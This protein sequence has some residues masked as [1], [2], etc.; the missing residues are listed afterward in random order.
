LFNAQSFAKSEQAWTE[1]K[2]LVFYTLRFWLRPPLSDESPYYPKQP[3]TD[4]ATK[5]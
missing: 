4:S 2:E 3:I 5:K 1:L